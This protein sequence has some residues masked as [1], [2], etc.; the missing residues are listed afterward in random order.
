MLHRHDE[1]HGLIVITQ[2]AHAHVSGQLARA[3][4]NAFVGEFSPREEVCLAAELHDIGWLAWE[5]SPTLNSETGTPH[6]FLDLP[7][8]AHIDIWS[9]AARTMLVLNRYAALLVSLHGTGLYARYGAKRDSQP[10]QVRDIVQRFMD[11]LRLLQQELIEELLC[12]AWY[13]PFADER[14]IDRNRRLLAAWDVMSLNIC[15][16]IREPH[17]IAHVPSVD[18]ETTITMQPLDT[19]PDHVAV[20]PWP[21]RDSSVSVRFDGRVLK[22]RFTDEAHMRMALDQAAWLSLTATLEPMRD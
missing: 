19:R 10:Q 8:K 21:F 17:I 13:A 6:S 2:P 16:G 4:G 14:I 1:Q 12:D 3:W 18:G 20:H 15:M 5:A 22:E 11:D 9:G 7:T